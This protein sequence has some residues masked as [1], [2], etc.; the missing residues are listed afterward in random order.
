MFKGQIIWITGAS[1]GIGEAL[2]KQLARKGASLILSGRNVSALERVAEA[3]GKTSHLILP[4]E[5]TDMDKLPEIVARA[6]EWKGRIDMLVNNAGISQRSLAID[7]QMAVYD[8]IID[9]DLRAPIALTQLVLPHMATHQSGRLVFI[10]SVAGKVGVPMRTAYCAAKHGLIGYADALRAEV[11]GLGIQV[12]VITPG[13]IK[14]NVSRNA[15]EADGSRRG[16]SDAAIDKGILADTAAATMVRA[17]ARGQREILVAR[18]IER[19]MPRLRRL[20]PNK[21]FDMIA[22]MMTAGYAQRMKGE[23]Q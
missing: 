1:S 10:S 23:Q 20:S 4:F 3:C 17:I 21:L 7:T 8:K 11:A 19:T 22:A 12:H 6:K 14:T 9:V 16:V 5:T 15:L 18:G 2:A 13:S